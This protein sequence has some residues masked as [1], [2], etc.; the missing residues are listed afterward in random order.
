[1]Y[2]YTDYPSAELFI[3][4]KSQGRI[5]KDVGSRLDRYRLRWNNVKYQPGEIKVVA[6]DADGR[7]AEEKIV[8][9]AGKA[10]ALK[11]ETDRREIAAD[12]DDLAFITVTMVDKDGN[13][14]PDA[15]QQLAFEVSG[16]GT[17]KAVCNGDA[18]S[19]ES[20]AQP[21]MRLFHG[22]LVL[23]VQAS[24]QQGEIVIRVRDTKNSVP[25]SE[26]SVAVN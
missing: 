4:G 12:G 7:K 1:M 9:T 25:A 20:F 6:Y 13:V 24:R 2:C 15:D 18:T 5:F 19:L 17:F 3:N 21:T 8:R 16:A 26:I 22:Q 10:A 11:L 14:V 23:V